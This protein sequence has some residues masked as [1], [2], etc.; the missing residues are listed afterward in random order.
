[1]ACNTIARGVICQTAVADAGTPRSRGKGPRGVRPHPFVLLL[2]GVVL[3]A[4]LAWV[5]SNGN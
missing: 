5:L 3:A 4:L 1:M 2:G